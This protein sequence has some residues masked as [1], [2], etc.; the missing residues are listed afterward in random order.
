MMHENKKLLIETKRL[1]L[2]SWTQSDK[3]AFRKMNADTRVMEHYPAP[4]SHA[5]SDALFDRICAHHEKHGF[6]FHVVELSA[7]STFVGFTGLAIPQWDAAFSPCIEVGWRLAREH[8]GYGYATEAARAELAFGFDALG[9][10][11]I[12]A[13]T[14]AINVRSQRVM[15][16]LGM[17]HCKDENFHHPA[18]PSQHPLAPHVLYRLPRDTWIRQYRDAESV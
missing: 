11:E 5:E 17:Q 3:P 2:R 8:W 10:E 16:R 6:G 14:A 13:F 7:T 15:H 18:V 9:I 12:V 4:L 1:R